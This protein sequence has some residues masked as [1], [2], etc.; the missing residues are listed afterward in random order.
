VADEE[1]AVA[2]APRRDFIAALGTLAAM[3]WLAG[4]AVGV[5]PRARAAGRPFRIRTLTA[6]VTVRDAGDLRAIDDAIAF[7]QRARKRFESEGYEVQT[8]RI[9][10]Q[11]FL[12]PIGVVARRRALEHLQLMDRWVVERGALLSLGP[13]IATDRL[14]PDFAPWAAEL[15]R[16]TRN[17]SCS[18]TV[19][20]P[21]QGMHPRA[22]RVAAEA[23]QAIA[24]AT[25]GGMGNFRFAAAANVPAGTPF[26]PAAV[27]DGRNSFAIGLE[28][29][30]FLGDAM[31]DA[32][33]DPAARARAVLEP[34]LREVE[35]LAEAAVATEQRLYIG[36]D[37]SPA[38]SRDSSI[39]AAIERVSG[40][41]FGSPGTLRTCSLMTE[42]VRS[43][44]VRTCGY[45]GLMLPVMEDPVLA[46]RAGEGRYG[47]QELLLYSSV[48]GTGL[49]V[50][51][52][53]G[54]TPLTALTAIVAD[55][56]SLAARLRKA[57]SVR[58]LLAPGRR[59]GQI[60]HFD[61]PLLTDCAVFRA[62]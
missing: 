41:P 48:C 42:V 36:I 9:A 39:G 35:R 19:A 12:D 27:H 29:A 16:S 55:T 24:R 15:I 14:D 38:P 1:G 57:L 47:L 26:F 56:A 58:L 33:G 49:D 46:Q 13:V 61:D 44:G 20:S 23:M 2:V 54:D 7:L 3:P 22:S 34:P 37:P 4:R 50:V 6:G 8:T 40:V 43:L 45:S 10:T 32:P 62:E 52:I 31:A 59:A 18:V 28:M 17:T 51:P 5:E 60:A 30:S 53:P 25:P 21:G 11:P